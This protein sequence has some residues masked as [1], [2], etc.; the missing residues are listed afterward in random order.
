MKLKPYKIM[1]EY[2]K[3]AFNAKYHIT[4]GDVCRKV[5]LTTPENKHLGDCDIVFSFSFQSLKFAAV[6]KVKMESVLPGAK[7]TF[8]SEHRSQRL[9]LLNSAKYIVIF[10]SDEYAQSPQQMEELHLALIRQRDEADRKRVYLV[11]C[12][13]SVDEP[14]YLQ[15]LSYSACLDDNLW[16]PTATSGV[17][18][19]HPAHHTA[20]MTMET[21]KGTYTCTRAEYLALSMVCLELEENHL[22]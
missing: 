16:R 20:R 5:E 22:R 12:E 19:S 7:C 8:L 2:R 9:Q 14:L 18:S 17:K 15:F 13:K 3:N 6:F 21:I 4:N 10:V 1:A 11:Q